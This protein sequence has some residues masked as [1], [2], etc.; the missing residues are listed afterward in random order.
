[1]ASYSGYFIKLRKHIIH[2]GKKLYIPLMVI[3]IQ[4]TD[5]NDS[6]IFDNQDV[7]TA[8]LLRQ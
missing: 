5:I 1:M 6:P 7:L 2:L 4:M 3:L 8:V